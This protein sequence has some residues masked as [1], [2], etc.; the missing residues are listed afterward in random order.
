MT[1][2]L[3]ARHR[4]AVKDLDRHVFWQPRR[5]PAEVLRALAEAAEEW[6]PTWDQYAER[7]PVQVLEER[8]AE[9]FG[10]PG[11]AWF[12]S[13]TMAQQAALR[14][15]CERAGH[16][17]VA[18]P[19]IAHPLVH[20]NEG[21][22]LLQGLEVVHLTRGR[23]TATAA[24][25]EAIPG[26]LAAVLLELPL[27]DAGCALP[28]WGELT[29]VSAAV[30]GRGAAMHFDGARLWESQPYWDRPLPEIAAL[31]DSIYVS[32]Y[33][34]L[35]GLSGAALVSAEDFLAEAR[36]WRQ[37]MGGT[38][39]RSTPE[40]LAA[41]V[42][43]RD[44]L[45]RMGEHLAWARALAEEL[46]AVGLTPC[47]NPPHTPTFQVFGPGQEDDVNERLVGFIERER[48]ELCGPWRGTPE[49]GRVCTEL[50]VATPALE[51]EPK[52]VAG[53]LAEVVL[54]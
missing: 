32:F 7:G 10:T 23:N 35:G 12:P 14:V 42:G 3:W 21:P 49:P 1:D 20:E 43:L 29:A 30:R 4:A 16:R 48:L 15:W 17:R 13:G 6:A 33:K 26:P 19:D 11:A 47:P 24:D 22:R 9:L 8:L 37:R 52:Q 45:P 39:F 38:L 34:G 36:L 44:A 18:M 5:R 40:V 28:S 54:G 31:A 50:M 2:E 53:W 41:L 51:H 25:V 27:R 46:T